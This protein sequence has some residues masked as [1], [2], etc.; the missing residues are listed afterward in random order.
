MVYA[1]GRSFTHKDLFYQEKKIRESAAE[2][3]DLRI[4]DSNIHVIGSKALNKAVYH[5]NIVV[6]EQ[7]TVKM[8]HHECPAVEFIVNRISVWR[9]GTYPQRRKLLAIQPRFSIV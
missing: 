2:R 7:L 6:D 8:C 3:R 1:S 4:L 5:Y 9:E